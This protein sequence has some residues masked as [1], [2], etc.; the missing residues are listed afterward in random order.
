MF[1]GENRYATGLGLRT[2]QT[3]GLGFR[4]WGSAYV[5]LRAYAPQAESGSKGLGLDP[6]PGL[7]FRL[8]GLGYRLWGLGFRDWGL[9]FRA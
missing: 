9:G 2:G 6:K 8:W 3:L 1:L 7:G 4:V 5:G